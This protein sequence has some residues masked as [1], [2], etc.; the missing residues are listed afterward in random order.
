MKCF[1]LGIVTMIVTISMNLV[2][3]NNTANSWESVNH[4]KN[5]SGDECAKYLSVGENKYIFCPMSSKYDALKTDRLDMLVAGRTACIFGARKIEPVPKLTR[6]SDLSDDT[7][8][9]RCVIATCAL[10]P[11]KRGE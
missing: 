3:F 8:L 9:E 5:C 2:I 1:P 6:S 7:N 11:K 10:A 4:P